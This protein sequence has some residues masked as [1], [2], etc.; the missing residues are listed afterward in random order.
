M[1]FVQNEDGV[2]CFPCAFTER[3][4][5][6]IVLQA[7]TFPE[8]KDLFHAH[9]IVCVGVGVGVVTL[10]MRCFDDDVL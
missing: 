5:R 2:D 6:R 10:L 9:G 3:N 4:K 7:K 1:P 8:P